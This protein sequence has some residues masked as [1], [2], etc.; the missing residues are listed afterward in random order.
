MVY[1]YSKSIGIFLVLFIFLTGAIQVTYA[2]VSMKELQAKFQRK[3][4]IKWSNATSEERSDF[5]YEVRGREAK[6]ER[7][8][9]VKGVEV[10]FY[11]REGYRKEYDSEWEEATEEEQEHFIKVYKDLKRKWEREKNDKIREAGLRARKIERDKRNAEKKLSLKRK[12]R[13]KRKLDKKKEIERRR[14]A[15]KKRLEAAKKRN[16]LL[17]KK[18]KGMRDS[19]SRD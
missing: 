15:E 19:R 8:E 18:L 14:K 4:G 6:E 17:L 13:E 16:N 11:I 5:M 3:T 10:P 1:R 2:S 9:R 12:E 7:E